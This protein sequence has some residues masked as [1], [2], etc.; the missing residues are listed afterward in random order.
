M[1]NNRRLL[2]LASGCLLGAASVLAAE[3]GD[4]LGIIGRIASNPQLTVNQP[5]KLAARL[6][7]VR[8]G[9]AADESAE[10]DKAPQATTGGYR[11]QVFSGNNPRTARSQAHSRAAAI[12]AEFPE[13]GSYVTFDSPYWRVKIGDFRSYDEAR[14]ALDLLKK[15][16]PGFASEM[17]PVRD[18][19][20][21]GN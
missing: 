9:S 12:R 2:I 20:K 18:R 5:E 11:I 15:H 8:S 7:P 16:F 17:R 21:N 3:P 1:I 10:G 6:L 13:W 4:S 19:I 14:A